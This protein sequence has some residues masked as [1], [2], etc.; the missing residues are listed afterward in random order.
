MF[1]GN[2]LSLYYENKHKLFTALQIKALQQRSQTTKM[3][4]V[5][6]K[7]QLVECTTEPNNDTVPTVPT[8]T[9]CSYNSTKA[10]HLEAFVCDEGLFV[11][12][13]HKSKGIIFFIL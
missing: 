9:V 10:P 1:N 3:C 12:I 11:Y 13:G 4:N 8:G 6:I 2:M 7:E 5:N